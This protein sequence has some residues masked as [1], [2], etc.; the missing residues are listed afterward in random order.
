M[1]GPGRDSY[2]FVSLRSEI[3]LKCFLR[4]GIVDDNVQHMPLEYEEV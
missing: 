1:N 3:R 2:F 4:S